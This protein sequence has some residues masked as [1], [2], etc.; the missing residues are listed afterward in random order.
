MMTNIS[1]TMTVQEL[2][3]KEGVKHETI[4]EI[5][6]YG[7]AQPLDDEQANDWTFDLDNAFWIRK[8]IKINQELHLDW[9]A[10]S[11]IVAL[12]RKKEMLENENAQLKQ[13]LSRL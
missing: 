12:I 6:D 11:M 1:L 8:A 4:V 5:V 2:C 13:R 7:I 3:Y 10:T 9:V